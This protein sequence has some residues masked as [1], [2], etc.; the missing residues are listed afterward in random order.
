MLSKIVK[1]PSLSKKN[2]SKNDPEY[3]RV[4]AMFDSI[5]TGAIMTD[6]N[7]M[8]ERVNDRAL[9]MVGFKR[10][11][12]IG[13]WFPQVLV[14][15]DKHK[16]VIET[17]D[18]PITQSFLTGK[19][20][21]TLTYYRKKDK[22]LL[23]AN[24]TVSPIIL[25][26]KP[27]GAIEVFE[28]VSLELEIDKMKS[29][30]ISIASHQLRTPLSAISIYAQMLVEGYKGKVSK[31]QQES[32]NTIIASTRRMNKLISALLDISK[33][34]TGKININYKDMQLDVVL[35]SIVEELKQDALKK[36]L[37][38]ALDIQ[39]RPF[40]INSDALFVGEIYSNL[41]SNAIKYTPREGKIKLSLW[42]NKKSYVFRVQDNGYGIP[43]NFQ[44]KIFTKFS[45]APN[46]QSI[47]PNGSGLGLYMAKEIAGIL[48]GRLWFTSNSKGTRFYFSLPK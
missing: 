13:K 23:A 48:Q 8:I 42:A 19:P 25:N 11:E 3:A 16:K 47:D 39:D 41:I 14:A 30:F 32:L 15:L 33:L 29:E 27:L 35:R 18:R 36:D 22:S 7:G 34:E 37:K 2:V 6:E 31:E 28:D 4:E 10:E 1:S 21:N 45:R 46:I 12:L 24:I 20:V 44:D 38:L 5:G 43:R 17:M 9:E 40:T 26:N